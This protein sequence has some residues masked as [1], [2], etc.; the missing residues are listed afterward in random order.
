MYP[1]DQSVLSY[2]IVTLECS[3]VK[4]VG[5]MA[6]FALLCARLWPNAHT[7]AIDFSTFGVVEWA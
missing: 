2:A 3:R 5:V 7:G 6:P 4:H 1:V